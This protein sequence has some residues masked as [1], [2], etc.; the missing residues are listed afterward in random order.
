MP[1]RHNFILSWKKSLP[2]RF[3]V[4]SFFLLPYE[5]L[6]DFCNGKREKMNPVCK[7][8]ICLMLTAFVCFIPVKPASALDTSA[9]FS[10]GYNDDENENYRQQVMQCGLGFSF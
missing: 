6:S 1:Q 5:N 8:V 9:E 4:D 3:H 7:N 10:T 2:Y